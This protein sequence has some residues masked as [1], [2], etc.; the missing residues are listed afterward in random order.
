MSRAI[1]FQKNRR[2]CAFSKPTQRNAH[3][4][5][6]RGGE[7]SRHV[8][9]KITHRTTPH[10]RRAVTRVPLPLSRWERRT[11]SASE[12]RAVLFFIP[13]ASPARTPHEWFHPECVRSIC[14]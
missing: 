12:G 2:L 11:R 6:P 7:G 10:Q 9:F 1:I 13:N 8:T 5:I 4:V 3:P 14:F